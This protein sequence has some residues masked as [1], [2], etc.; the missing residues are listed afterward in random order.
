[1]RKVLTFPSCFFFG[2]VSPMD[3]EEPDGFM[4]RDMILPIQD[5]YWELG[6]QQVS[7]ERRH[8][9]QHNV[10]GCLQAFLQL[11]HVEDVMNTN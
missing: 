4:P 7:L 10:H 5:F 9:R 3:L 11:R 1:M 8:F 6:L 2:V